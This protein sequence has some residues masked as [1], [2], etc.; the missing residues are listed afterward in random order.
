M[1]GSPFRLTFDVRGPLLEAAR[2]CE[3][4]VFLSWYGNTADQLEREYGGY[5]ESSV[6]I[7][8]SDD[9]GDVAGAIRLIV[10]GVAGLKTLHDMADPPWH[11]DGPRS[12]RAAGL[13]LDST[14]DVATLGVR[15]GMGSKGV[16]AAAALYHGLILATRVNEVTALVSIMDER[17]RSLLRSVGV[18]THPLPGAVT[19]PYL[20]SQASTPVYGKM[21]HALDTWRRI[22]P[23]AFRLIAQGNGLE[24][25]R[26]P[27][28]ATFVLGSRPLTIDLTEP[29]Q[30]VPSAP[31]GTLGVDRS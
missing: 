21:T 19:A 5:A 9:D 25:V 3:A 13:D 15:D 23:E 31:A 17:V 22:A 2:G 20:G 24:G 27:D 29:A 28:P 14:W 8:L 12:A 10:P 11:L 1:A 16:M 7:T 4:E 6:F 26:V 18:I 30:A